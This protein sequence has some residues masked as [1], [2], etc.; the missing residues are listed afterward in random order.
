MRGWI[1][2]AQELRDPQARS[3]DFGEARALP[4]RLSFSYPTPV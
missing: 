4:Y 3:A 2:G 1:A